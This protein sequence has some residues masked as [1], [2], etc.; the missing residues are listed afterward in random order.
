VAHGPHGAERR[1]AQAHLVD[2]V[3]AEGLEARVLGRGC[4]GHPGH[5]PHQRAVRGEGADTAAELAPDPD[6]AETGRLKDLVGAAGPDEL[7]P[8]FPS[9]EELLVVVAG[10][11]AGRFSAVVPGWMGGEIGSRPI[12]RAI[13]A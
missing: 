5:H 4:D 12:T 2:L 7:I 10:G 9:V 6:G 1:D 13:E 11:T 8:K 3:G